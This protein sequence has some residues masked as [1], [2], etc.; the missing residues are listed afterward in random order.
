MVY[1]D[2]DD[3]QDEGSEGTGG[4]GSKHLLI[5]NLFSLLLIPATQLS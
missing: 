2:N 5:V 4:S 1:P 3:L